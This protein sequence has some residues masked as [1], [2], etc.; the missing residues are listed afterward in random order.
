MSSSTRIPDSTSS[1]S[2]F[3]EIFHSCS[4]YSLVKKTEVTSVRTPDILKKVFSL[5]ILCLD[6]I[7]NFR[8]QYTPF[9]VFLSTMATRRPLKL[10]AVAMK[11]PKVPP[12]TIT[13]NVPTALSD[14]SD[15]LN[16]PALLETTCWISC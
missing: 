9:S 2:S 10:N 1:K 8:I 7:I 3:L 12:Q 4:L 16:K 5:Q 11:I 13:S 14:K 6:S 15:W